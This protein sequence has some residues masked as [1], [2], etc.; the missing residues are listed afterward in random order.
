[1]ESGT[2]RQQHFSRH[3]TFVVR[4]R[5][6]TVETMATKKSVSFHDAEKI[7]VVVCTIPNREEFDEKDVENLFYS[8]SDYHM[9][10]TSA[11]VISNESERYGFSKNLDETFTEK[12]KVAQDNLNLWTIHGHMRRGLERWSNREHGDERQK[13]QF[14]AVMS[15]LRAQDDM[16]SASRKVD[17][18][19]L[20]RVSHKATRTAR[21]FARMMGKADSF[22]VSSE[23]SIP[24]DVS[25]FTEAMG[26][27]ALSTETSSEVVDDNEDFMKES[28]HERST[29]RSLFSFGR[30]SSTKGRGKLDDS[31]RGKLDDTRGLSRVA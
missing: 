18:E 9:S 7:A 17:D 23:A 10:R 27:V 26:S 1:M 3:I 12:G 2:I 22:A 15:V 16:S 20:R 11:K 30:K 28:H 19:K 8:R 29:K 13:E 6:T 24:D 4:K 25:S 5:A 14:Q 31:P 21:H